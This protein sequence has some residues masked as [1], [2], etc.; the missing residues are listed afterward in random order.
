MTTNINLLEGNDFLSHLP[1]VVDI[2][3][4]VNERY[5]NLF[6]ED[7]LGT[8]RALV[9]SF[10]DE[11]IFHEK[12]LNWI[13]IEDV[14]NKRRLFAWEEHVKPYL[15][16]DAL[17]E[18]FT[19]LDQHR[20]L[21]D[22]SFL[23]GLAL[24]P[25]GVIGRN[26]NHHRTKW[27]F[28]GCS[29]CKWAIENGFTPLYAIVNQ[30]FIGCPPPE[31][32]DLSEVERAII[33]PVHGYGYCFNYSGG[34]MMSLKGTMT[35]MR[36]EERKIARAAMTLERMGLTNHIVILLTGKMTPLQRK[37]ATK[38]VN[39]ERLLRA[40]DWLINNHKRWQNVDLDDIREELGNKMPVVVDNS[41]EVASE[42]ENV[43]KNELFTCYIPDG[44]TNHT[45]GGFDEPGAFKQYVEQMQ[46]QGYDPEF[47]MELTRE[48]LKGTSGND[49]LV[50]CCLLQFP[51]GIG[52]VEEQRILSDGSF[53]SRLD[54]E[55][56]LQHLTR[57]S[58][59]VMHKPHFALVIY[60]LMSRIRLLN[61]ARL[62]VK[63]KLNCDIIANGWNMEDLSRTI[64]HRRRGYRNTGTTA[65]K[66]ILKA[67]DACSRA[68]PHTNEAARVARSTA[69]TLQHYFGI[70]TIWLTVNFDDDNSFL[71]EVLADNPIDSDDPLSILTDEQLDER[72]RKR[73]LL[74][75]E[76]PGLGSINFEM[77]IHIV[78]EEVI[79][80]DMRRNRPTEK[81]GMYGICEAIAMALEEQG[82]LSIH[83]HIT[84]W[85]R[86]FQMIRKTLFFGTEAGK[87]TARQ[88]IRLYH[89]RIATTSLFAG[90]EKRQIL[91]VL[92]HKCTVPQRKRNVPIVV[93]DQQLRELRHRMGY[94]HHKGKFAYCAHC[95][96]SWTY[97]MFVESIARRATDCEGMDD[98][99]N[100]DTGESV[101]P[102]SRLKARILEFQKQED[103]D[104]E[105][106][107]PTMCINVT[108]NHH[109]SKHIKRTCFKCAKKSK[110]QHTCGP[111]CECRFRLPDI[112][113]SRATVK[114][115]SEGEGVKWYTWDGSEKKQP[116]VAILPKR[117][118]YDLFQ[119]VSCPGISETKLSCNTNIAVI[120]DGPLGQYSIKYQ[121]KGTQDDDQREYAQVE[122]A[123]KK[124]SEAGRTHE[125]NRRETIRLIC[126]GSFAHNRTNVIGPSMAPILTRQKERFYFS[127]NT[128]LCPLQDLIRILHN[129][130]IDSVLKYTPKG[131]TFFES[132]ALHYLCRP[133]ELEDLS[134]K[135]FY[136]MYGVHHNS[137]KRKRDD[138]LML[139]L[140]E[141][142]YFRH[143]SA[144]AYD[145]VH[146]G[147]KPMEK[148]ALVKIC[149]WQFP[150]T[151]KFNQS[152]M[153][154]TPSEMSRDME[155]YA[156]LVLGL[157]SAYRGPDDF[158]P[159]DRSISMYRCVHRLQEIYIQEFTEGPRIVF[160]EENMRFLQNI[161][162]AAYNSMR[163]R[164]KND[165]LHTVTEPFKGDGLVFD[166]QEEESDEEEELEEQ[167]PY[168][169]ILDYMDDND[170][171][172]EDPVCLPQH[173]SDF[174]FVEIRNKGKKG[175]GHSSDF[176]T[177]P[178]A[179]TLQN[180][181]EVETGSSGSRD[182]NNGASERV[183]HTKQEIIAVLLRRSQSRARESV[184][185][186]N[187]T[188]KVGDAN[189][190]VESILEWAEAA[191]LDPIQKRA[192]ECIIASFLLTFFDESEDDDDTATSTGLHAKFRR[193]KKHLLKLKG[194]KK[195]QLICL[196]HGPGGS[197]KSTVINLVTA[198][199]Q[200]YCKHL[201]HPFT[202]RTIVIT[203]MSG[204]AATLLHGET[205]HKALGLNQNGV[206][207]DMIEA[208]KDTRLLIIDE[209]S[210]ATE[211]ELDRVYK[212]TQEL[213]CNRF[214]AFG[215]LNIVFA[216]DYSQLEP[217]G[218]GRK[219]IYST[220]GCPSFNAQL[221]TYIE[222]DGKHRFRKDPE[223]GE[224]LLRFREGRPTLDDIRYINSNC[225]VNENHQPPPG[226]Q[227]ATYLNSDRDAV[228]CCVFEQYCEA[229]G[230]KTEMWSGAAVILMDDLAMKNDRKNFVPIRSN[231]IQKLFWS[232]IGENGCHD[233]S[234]FRKRVDPTLKLYPNCPLMLTG[235]KDVSNGQAN[236]SRLFCIG[237]KVKHGEQPFP[238]TLASGV[239]IQA[240]RANQIKTI[241][242]RQ[243]DEDVRPQ[244]FCVE[245]AKLRFSCQLEMRTEKVDCVMEGMQFPLISNS[246]TTGHKLQG[247]T[248]QDLLVNEWNY[249]QNWAYVVLSRVTTMA[250]LF[251]RKPLSEDLLKYMMPQSMKDMIQNFRDTIALK[252]LERS[253][254]DDILRQ[255][256]MWREN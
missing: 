201:D 147:V 42:N 5:E 76:F 170:T 244:E 121:H 168:D 232:S 251:L 199:A 156:E 233:T 128:R 1:Y 253:D 85:I 162:D 190:S 81:P 30:N 64:N 202:S 171:T 173:M 102:L 248:A 160:T 8:K 174:S 94:D 107:T 38:K 84:A 104:P 63:G 226:V 47:K 155:K 179:E 189:G 29:K 195:S 143:P 67:V 256:R 77:L 249:T 213:M 18:S 223:W 50:E 151:C 71:M 75:L 69:E 82:R 113:R 136:E 204:V 9:C 181:I 105:E 66:K 214:K 145:Q 152:I 245:P 91:R 51:Y 17:E 231:A 22:R 157:L 237:F 12:D 205:T 33:T 123:M 27:G 234:K 208:W 96:H 238:L 164:V 32:T 159:E 228:N 97:E 177:P 46:E 193:A 178:C 65:S 161:Q 182:P 68:L 239:I 54:L 80:W 92:E 158:M 124:L 216:G 125:D 108:Y 116:L 117:G 98:I 212:H 184:F 43:E 45:D 87:C 141:T 57:L 99:I 36:I 28:S 111:S 126:S 148:S 135:S 247:Y 86:G 6:R 20:A 240:F 218:P 26:G 52:G 230:T 131:D 192:F 254:Y 31:L 120:T 72:A 221:E 185:K 252:L 225:L 165:E 133:E 211:T 109:T 3:Q 196:L 15:R 44:A 4:R 115:L 14:K 242:V 187:K 154:A 191:C 122:R 206:K 140:A 149:Q 132:Q 227:V 25:R 255:E 70:G 172:D 194:D 130:P 110:S 200:E 169:V 13:K 198:Y 134:P 49:E 78:M 220:N 167:C 106:D 89:E 39:T 62:Q 207:E 180:W 166:N 183:V 95:S 142:E 23:K 197:G 224:R 114:D 48:L 138:E 150:D 34:G 176:P 35:F 139:F 2:Q 250:G 209:I 236:G 58:Q 229:Y 61:R 112:P 129:E 186:Y 163:F 243:E 90:M 101:I 219:P 241:S 153:L 37:N 19:F 88:I 53:K 188:A 203:A 16:I 59:P 127:H 100:S 83:G 217:P 246:C 10:C 41:K 11:F 55:E 93:P 119:N 56:F 210:F 60:T 235:N 73:K 21:G 103:V 137:G 144:D 215:G 24:S 175:C 7:S 40:V 146:Q 222:L 79:G 118:P 74:R